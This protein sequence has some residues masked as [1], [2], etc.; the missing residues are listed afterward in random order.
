MQVPLR[1]FR[2]YLYNGKKKSKKKLIS[3]PVNISKELG[4]MC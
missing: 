3:I 4:G 1:K 2:G